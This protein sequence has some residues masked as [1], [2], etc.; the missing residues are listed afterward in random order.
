MYWWVMTKLVHVALPLYS[1]SQLTRVSPNEFQSYQL[2][3]NPALQRNKRHQGST[4]HKPSTI[5]Q[6][7][8]ANT[9]KLTL[10]LDIRSLFSYSRTIIIGLQHQ[11]YAGNFYCIVSIC[12]HSV[13]YENA[14]KARVN[15]TS[16][17]TITYIG[18]N[19]QKK[20][21]C[22]RCNI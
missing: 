11:R 6:T 16:Q 19:W 13:A 20:F 21:H 4:Q 17:C 9:K 2:H 1:L 8:F 3:N 12:I 18:P 15:H 10:W 14:I 7:S 5:P 22:V